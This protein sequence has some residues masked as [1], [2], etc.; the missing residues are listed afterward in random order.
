MIVLLLIVAAIS[1]HFSDA[2][3]VPD[4]SDWP[5]ST[6]VEALSP[7]RIVLARNEDSERPGV[8]GLEWTGGHAI[9]GAI[10]AAGA[11]TV[12][13]RL[14][15]VRGYLVPEMDVGVEAN[16]YSG[17]PNQ[18]FGLPSAEVKVPA[19]S[20]RCRPGRFP[21]LAIPGRSSCTGSTAPRRTTYY[22][23]P[24]AGHTEAWNVAPALY[25]RRLRSRLARTLA[26]N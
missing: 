12:I 7:G 5:R 15:A 26:T 3:L 23:V 13:R 6:R 19:S 17:D 9:V 25:Q 4:H 22:R 10:V 11:D 18:A 2:V 24:H 20:A 8:Y 14:R 21:P 1:W 16:V